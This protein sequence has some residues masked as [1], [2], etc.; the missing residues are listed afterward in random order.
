MPSSKPDKSSRHPPIA[1]MGGGLVIATMVGLLL[2]QVRARPNVPD[3]TGTRP[4]TTAAGARSGASDRGRAPTLAGDQPTA[5]VPVTPVPYVPP[6]KSARAAPK[7]PPGFTPAWKIRPP[8][9][10]AVE[11][12]RR[13]PVPPPDPRTHRPSKH[14]PGG[15]NGQRPAR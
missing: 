12:A 8:R 7:P 9:P 10:Y 14:N 13:T 3:A 2:Y 4:D 11:P 15:V 5:L 1:L 6:W